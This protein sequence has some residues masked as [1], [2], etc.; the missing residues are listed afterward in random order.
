MKSRLLVSVAAATLAVG[1][2]FVT[3]E[4]SDKGGKGSQAPTTQ[5]PDAQPR[6]QKEGQPK[7][8]QPKEDTKQP[9]AKE[10]AAEPKAKNGGP[11]DKQAQPGRDPDPKDKPK[12]K[13]K[14]TTE[15][16]AQKGQEKATTD[17]PAKKDK[18]TTTDAPPTK[19]KAPGGKDTVQLTTQQRTE[20]RQTIIKQGD[21]PRVTN[22]NFNISVG[23]E[24]PSTVR[25]VVLPARVV[26]I[27][28]QWRG[29]RYF[30]VGERIII[31]EPDR[32]VI[33]F[34]IEA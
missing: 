13:E 5:A 6:D 14:A 34:I 7:A 15:K 31:V 16:P 10:R 33:V 18:A 17:K 1:T 30:I 29:Y 25:V 8:T 12:T 21:A 20:I 26:E 19:G 22:V 23:A 27:Y 3:A 2:A 28:P 24:V 9:K 11:K 4:P 32:L